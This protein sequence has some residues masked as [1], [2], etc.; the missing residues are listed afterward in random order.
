ME[1]ASVCHKKWKNQPTIRE[2]WTEQNYELH[3]H[4]IDAILID[5]KCAREKWRG[6]LLPRNLNSAVSYK[7]M[8][9]QKIK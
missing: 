9:S 2:L 1:I 4:I 8:F 3:M 5:Q 6:S 7:I